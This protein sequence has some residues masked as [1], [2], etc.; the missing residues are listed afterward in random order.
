MASG[1]L[2]DDIGFL[3]DKKVVL[4][5]LHSEYQFSPDIDPFTVML[6]KEAAKLYDKM[7]DNTMQTTQTAQ[8]FQEQWHG[9][10]ERTQS[11]YSMLH[12]G[13]YKA[14]AH[15]PYLSALH[16]V[17][18]SL[19]A[20]MGVPLDWWCNGLTVMLEKVFGVIFY[21]Q[22]LSHLPI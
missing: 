19:A 1:K 7:Q 16:V 8:E 9:A 3:G 4:Q 2:L 12:F 13:H 15:D 22:T 20:T 18:I 10:K 11:S 21:S 14:T 5:I 17:K 6:L